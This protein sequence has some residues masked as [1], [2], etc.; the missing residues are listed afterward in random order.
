LIVRLKSHTD[1]ALP[2]GNGVSALNLLKLHSLLGDEGYF[3]KA[4]STI[5]LIEND[6]SLHPNAAGMM[7]EAIDSF[8]RGLKT[9]VVVD[10]VD[11]YFT[12]SSSYSPNALVL[13][14]S[15]LKQDSI[16]IGV[17]KNQRGFYLC[18]G[19]VCKAPTEDIKSAQRF[20]AKT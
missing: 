1:D 5:G 13:N 2:S 12:L 6:P 20:V 10:D 18:E 14:R 3:D 9:V 15:S 4:K 16:G 7:L 8:T 17:S 11:A 19:Q